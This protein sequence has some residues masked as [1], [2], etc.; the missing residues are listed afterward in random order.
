MDTLS[1][2][3]NA[4]FEAKQDNFMTDLTTIESIDGIG[5][6]LL[7]GD[8]SL[9][10]DNKTTERGE[11][12]RVRNNA[13][14]L[15]IKFY[16]N[17][18]IGLYRGIPMQKNSAG[19]VIKKGQLGLTKMDD[20]LS[21]VYQAARLDDPYADQL[22]YN[23]HLAS[24]QL[25]ATIKSFNKVIADA[26]AQKLTSG[27]GAKI[28]KD[29]NAPS[30]NVYLKTELGR[31]VFWQIRDIDSLVLSNLFCRQHAILPR[32]ASVKISGILSSTL[33]NMYHSIFLWQHTGVTRKDV[34]E[35]NQ[36]AKRAAEVNAR[37]PLESFILDCSKRS[38]L[39]PRISKRPED[40]DTDKQSDEASE[41][42]SAE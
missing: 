38:S 35:N 41:L 19:V 9:F 31:V 5:S 21:K 7:F 20:L 15:T 18:A 36:V 13:G 33:W 2:K 40:V 10:D 26:I 16:T 30:F 32:D 39:A 1:Y 25:D 29:E 6:S 28:T 3:L 24:N 11:N 34:L 37:L 4:N 12:V 27:A 14:E 22:I 8:I 17:N 42:A 23:L